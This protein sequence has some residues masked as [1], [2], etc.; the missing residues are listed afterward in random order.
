MAGHHAEPLRLALNVLLL[1]VGCG[2]LPDG[3]GAVGQ[4]RPDRRGLRHR[5]RLL[6]LVRGTGS[7]MG[8]GGG[9][10]S[11]VEAEVAAGTAREEEP[12]R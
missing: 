7:T 9:E 11:D 6:L 2:V 8:M 1:L 12:S 10:A 4:R 3:G 5:F